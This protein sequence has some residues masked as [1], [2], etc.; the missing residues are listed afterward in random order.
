MLAELCAYMCR[1]M[2]GT[3]PF[4]DLLYQPS[5]VELALVNLLH[6]IFPL[7]LGGGMIAGV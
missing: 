2:I 1:F 7:L 3:E 4:N 6:L 5:L